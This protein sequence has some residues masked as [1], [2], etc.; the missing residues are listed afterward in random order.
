M[1]RAA[2]RVLRS[3]AVVVGI[4]ASLLFIAVGLAFELQTYGDGSIFSYAV[5]T[6]EVWAF[7]WHN[8]ATRAATYALTLAPGELAVAATG[9]PS[10]GVFVY[11]LCLFAA[12]AVSLAA[13]FTFDHAPGRPYFVFACAANAL[14]APLVFGFPTEMWIAHALFWPAF[15]CAMTAPPSRAASI[16]LAGLFVA[17]ALSHEGGLVLG[18]GIAVACGLRGLRDAYFLRALT[19]LALALGAWFSINYF[20]QPD[21]YFGEVRL[22]AASE[23]FDAKIFA[24]PLL[25]L[26][27]AT[28]GAYGSLWLCLQRLAPF[29]APLFAALPVVAGLVVW[30]AMFDHALHADNRYYLRTILLIATCGLAAVCGLLQLAQEKS[31]VARVA[32][33]RASLAALRTENVA[34]FALGA[35]VLVMLVHIVETA[36]FVRCFSAYRAAVRA[37][38]AGEA[39]DPALGAPFLVSSQRIDGALER[40]SWFSTTPYLSALVTDFRPNRLVVDPAGNYFWLS[41]ATATEAARASRAVPQETREMI[42]VYSCLHRK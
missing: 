34:R 33:L 11:G 21:S 32:P 28:L 18:F 30:W 20:L 27:G 25:L 5:A 17:L 29:A 23:F 40:L 1:T 4:A 16:V 19:C 3:G 31:T 26:I 37:L 2:H 6:R 15:A 35:A 24:S 10:A 13:T 39:A 22:R 36:K 41:C 14:L 12:P 8:I 7:H 42:R 9:A 38:A